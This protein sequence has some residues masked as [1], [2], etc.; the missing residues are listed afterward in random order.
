MEEQG[1]TNR[2]VDVHKKVQAW[3]DRIRLSNET[4]ADLRR[5]RSVQEAKAIIDKEPF[6]PQ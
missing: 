5:K 3:K 1:Y 4:D 2:F 6:S